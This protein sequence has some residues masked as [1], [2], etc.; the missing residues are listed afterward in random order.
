VDYVAKQKMIMT[1]Y[2]A[3]FESR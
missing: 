1:S 3:H 2:Q